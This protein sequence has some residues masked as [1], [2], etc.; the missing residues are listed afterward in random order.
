VHHQVVQ[1]R[2]KAVAHIFLENP[3][4]STD[5]TCSPPFKTRECI[6]SVLERAAV[7]GREAELD[8][9][10]RLHTGRPHQIRGQMA[11][12]GLPVVGDRLYTSEEHAPDRFV[13]SP[14]LCLR[15][16]E[17]GFELAAQEY[18]FSVEGDRRFHY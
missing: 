10:V 5:D 13:D 6:L 2:N 15:S 16:V 9:L 18:S 8:L 3:P 4:S 12:L 7:E 11:A 1:G 17:L 14:G